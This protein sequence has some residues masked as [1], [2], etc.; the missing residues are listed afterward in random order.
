[1]SQIEE[2]VDQI[3]SRIHDASLSSGEPL[4]SAVFFRKEQKHSLDMMDS[5]LSNVRS[6]ADSPVNYV[7]NKGDA[8]LYR[9]EEIFLGLAAFDPPP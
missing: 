7:Q 8:D 4:V 2:A 6:Y 5:L 9:P 3:K 1:M